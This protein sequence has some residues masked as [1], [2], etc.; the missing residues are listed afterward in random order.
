M[1]VRLS[2]VES[3][4]LGTWCP[5]P[6]GGG[7]TG[8]SPFRMHC[9]AAPAPSRGSLPP[10][11]GSAVFREEPK[12]TEGG[13]STAV[14]PAL[15]WLSE[16]SGELGAGGPELSP[17]QGLVPHG[18]VC[19]LTW[20]HS[21][22]LAPSTQLQKVLTAPWPSLLSLR[23]PPLRPEPRRRGAAAPILNFSAWN[24]VVQSPSW[25]G[26]VQF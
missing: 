6:L 4:P 24:V 19:L 8:S 9:N 1:G 13:P 10:H 12:A 22:H 15:L 20:T 21:A 5:A 2:P 11:F 23:K 26:N 3:C 16:W 14:L 7:I 17:R 25:L 18:K